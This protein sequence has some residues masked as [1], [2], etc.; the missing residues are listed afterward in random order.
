M[1]K[2]SEEF[3]YNS[4]LLYFNKIHESVYLYGTYFKQS[5]ITV[6]LKLLALVLP[7]YR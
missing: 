4:N 7:P 1:P 3:T 5:C 2:K 6:L